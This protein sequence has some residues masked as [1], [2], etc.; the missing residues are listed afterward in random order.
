MQRIK[1]LPERVHL[2]SLVGY[3]QYARVQYII[4]DSVP[5]TLTHAITV[6]AYKQE[7]GNPDF[8]PLK[9]VRLLK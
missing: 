2:W 6:E 8:D 9:Q 3:Y 7:K 5:R 1:A 4:P